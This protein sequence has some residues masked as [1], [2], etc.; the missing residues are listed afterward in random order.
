MANQDSTSS[1]GTDATPKRINITSLPVEIQTEIFSYLPFQDQ[2]STAVVCPLW[3]GI[4]LYNE[5]LRR[6]RYVK[7]FIGNKAQIR[8]HKLLGSA[9]QW[10]CNLFSCVIDHGTVEQYR[11][12]NLA[13]YSNLREI[14]M[15][16]PR[17]VLPWVDISDSPFLDEPVFLSLEADLRLE[18]T[19]ALPLLAPD[20]R[21]INEL[22]DASPTIP[23][24][25]KLVHLCSLWALNRERTTFET[26]WERR[27]LNPVKGTTLKEIV[28]SLARETQL[29]AEKDGLEKGA[30]YEMFFAYSEAKKNR[31][32][33]LYLKVR[34]QKVE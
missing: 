24:P 32:G 10:A 16:W 34:L 4:L 5:S 30:R 33:E 8:T 12:C 14:L 7:T 29:R 11:F 2:I 13:N 25:P 31:R 17:L 15:T 9:F 3:R 6:S 22:A 23:K 27:R 20:E 19:S 21:G 26:W 28:N 1:D 18:E